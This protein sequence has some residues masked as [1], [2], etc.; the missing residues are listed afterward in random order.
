MVKKWSVGVFP[1]DVK[2]QDWKHDGNFCGQEFQAGEC[3]IAESG[4]IELPH[5][6]AGP[7]DESELIDGQ[8]K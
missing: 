1:K 4:S 2:Q 3:F 7:D 6:C 5:R 8:K